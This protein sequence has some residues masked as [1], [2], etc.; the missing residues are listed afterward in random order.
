[1]ADDDE[2]TEQ[3][4]QALLRDAMQNNNPTSRLERKMYYEELFKALPLQVIL[5]GL[6]AYELSLLYMDAVDEM[7]PKE[8]AQ[9]VNEDAD[10]VRYQVN[11]IYAKIRYRVRKLLLEGWRP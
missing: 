11:K 2:Q 8:I 5:G 9:V 6:S 7:S 10:R 3:V 1:M 4:R